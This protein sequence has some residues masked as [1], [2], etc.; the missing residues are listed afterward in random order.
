MSIKYRDFN[1]SQQ[2]TIKKKKYIRHSN[3][4]RRNKR[5]LLLNKGPIYYSF[6]VCIL[7]VKQ[8]TNEKTFEKIM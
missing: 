8:N 4:T 6:Y 2:F 1:T 3:Q 7:T 5:R